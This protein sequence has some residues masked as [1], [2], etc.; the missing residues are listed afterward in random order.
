MHFAGVCV[1]EGG[2]GREAVRGGGEV[3]SGGLVG[4]LFRTVAL[5]CL[6]ER[7]QMRHRHIVVFHEEFQTGLE[8]AAAF[9]VTFSVLF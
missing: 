6:P 4:S 8:R 9:S 5:W 1:E 2:G 7:L 3:L